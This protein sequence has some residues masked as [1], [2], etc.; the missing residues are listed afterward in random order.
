M[1]VVRGPVVHASRRVEGAGWVVAADSL[2]VD[3]RH[4]SSPTPSP[5]FP[6]PF[7]RSAAALGEISYIRA[8]TR[9]PLLDSFSLSDSDA[10]AERTYQVQNE[11]KPVELEST[12]SDGST[13]KASV[14]SHLNRSS[15]R[16]PIP[17]KSGLVLRKLYDRFHGRQRARVLVDNQM[18][19]WWYEPMEDRIDRWAVSDFGIDRN[20][21]EGKSEI[22]ISIDPPPGTPL[23]SVSQIEVFGLFDI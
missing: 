22:Q 9:C 10:R 20:L 6:V 12:F 11:S 21:L 13:H 8:A 16:M 19:G 1:E 15:W 5:E 7:F 18:A 14:L 17:E 23:W 4:E 3:D 2:S